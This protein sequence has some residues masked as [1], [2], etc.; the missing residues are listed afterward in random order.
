[1]IEVGLPVQF[2]SAPLRWRRL[3]S[4][5]SAWCGP[6]PIRLGRWSVPE[7]AKGAQA[8]HVARHAFISYVREDARKVD[9]LQW[10]LEEA[11]VQVWRDTEDL[12]PGED[13]R[14]GIRQAIQGDALVFIA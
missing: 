10:K 11:G 2:G 13:W 1:M 5:Q 9:R 6:A 3:M 8:D 4:A 12:W 14:A 7:R